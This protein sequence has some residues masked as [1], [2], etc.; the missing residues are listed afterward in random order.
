[1][2]NLTSSENHQHLTDDSRYTLFEALRLRFRVHPDVQRAANVE[3]AR[4]HAKPPLALPASSR[5]SGAPYV[6]FSSTA[7][8]E[9]RADQ[10]GPAAP[11]RNIATR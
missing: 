9:D 4:G 10:G 7:R 1:M 6:R 5:C 2:F 3:D 11:G 8:T